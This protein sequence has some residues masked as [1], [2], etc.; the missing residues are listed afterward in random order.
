[1]TAGSAAVRSTL[2]VPPP[3]TNSSGA[4]AETAAT[5]AARRAAS[6]RADTA[7]IRRTARP[8]SGRPRGCVL[9]AGDLRLVGHEPDEREARPRRPPARASAAASRGGV[10]RG[11][12]HADVHA[13]AAPRAAR[14]RRRGRPA[15]RPPRRAGRRRRSGRAAST[16]VDHQRHPRGRGLVAGQPA[17]RR[18][19]GRRVPDDDVGADRVLAAPATAPRPASRRAPRRSPAGPAP[20]AAPPGCAPT[21]SPPGSAFPTARRTRSAALAS[22]ASRSRTANGGSR[23][24]VAPSSRARARSASAS[25]SGQAHHGAACR[26]P[27]RRVNPAHPLTCTPRSSRVQTPGIRASDEGVLRDGSSGTA[28]EPHALAQL[29]RQRARRRRGRAARHPPTRSPPS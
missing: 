5:T 22:S 3:L 11:A 10:H 23:S 9:H 24:A 1:M 16:R 8:R 18:P 13:P 15:G 12:A 20:G 27:V 19:V 17:Q 28:R 29:G 21:C 14:R 4:T 6:S 2:P 7:C 26:S 25:C